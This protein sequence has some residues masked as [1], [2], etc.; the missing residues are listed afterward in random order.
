MSVMELSH[1]GPEFEGII[2]E[3][4][5]SLRTLLAIPPNYRVLFLQGGAT[6]LFS[7]I[8]LNLLPNAEACADYIV[9]GAWS[10]KAAAE[11]KKYG[12]VNV[13]N[14]D[15]S[16][17]SDLG[18]ELQLS[19]QASY[20][21]YCAN[22]TIH[23]VEFAQPPA[24][25]AD[26]VLV[27]DM[28]SNILSRPV[29]VAKFGIIYGGAQKN[30]GCSG[31]TIVIVRDD[32]LGKAQASC[33]EMLDLFIHAKNGSLYNTPPTWSIYIAG[34][35]F[36]WALAEGGVEEFDR[37]SAL[38]AGSVYSVIDSSAGFYTCPVPVH[39]RSRMNVPFRIQGGDAKLEKEFLAA[40]EKRHMLQLAGHR[41]VGGIRAS[42][43]NAVDVGMVEQ[44]VAFMKEF[45]AA[46]QAPQA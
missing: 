1:R 9:T 35:V 41:S 29:D 27:A 30:I 42:L 24:V 3:A 20:V 12:C 43:Y 36:K 39:M 11:A 13:V 38:K 23:G 15:A 4:E 33:P 45:Q 5:K 25:P 16:G 2:R 28:S 10:Q 32:L 44:L 22:E 17:M 26:Q 37:R 6:T 40:A 7:A 34:L 46:K 8:P 18:K 19:P 21:Y 14:A 31:V